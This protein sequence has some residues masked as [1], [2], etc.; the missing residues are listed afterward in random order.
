MQNTSKHARMASGPAP[1]FDNNS[2]GPAVP[3]LL[4]VQEAASLLRISVSSV[5]RL[6]QNRQL[7]FIKVGGSVRFTASDLSAYVAQQRVGPVDQ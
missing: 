2:T 6:Q 1:L 3:C 5:R 7:P 4:T